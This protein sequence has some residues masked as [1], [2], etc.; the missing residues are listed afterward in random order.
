[1]PAP[2][3]EFDYALTTIDNDPLCTTSYINLADLG[4]A[5]SPAIAGNNI[6]YTAF[7][8]GAA[9]DFYGD[10][11][12]GLGIT[13]DGIIVFDP[14]T[15]Y[16]GTPGAP[17]TLPDPTA[18]NNLLALL[19]QDMEIVYNPAAGRGVSLAEIDANTV[20]VEFDE[21][22][23]RS[24]PTDTYTFELIARRTP[25]VA[26]GEFEFVFAY[27]RL[28]RPLTGPLTVGIENHDSSLAQA[29]VNNAGANNKLRNPFV[30]CL[31]RV[32]SAPPATLT[33]TATVTAA[34]RTTIVNSALIVTDPPG[35]EPE[36]A[37]ATLTVGLDAY[38]PEAGPDQAVNEGDPV[39]F[40]GSL[41]VP[42]LPGV[43]YPTT[44]NWD[45]S[46]SSS[47]SGILAP[48]HIYPDN[49]EYLVTFTIQDQEGAPLSDTLLVSVHN[50]APTLYLGGSTSQPQNTA[51]A[52]FGSFIDPGADTWTATVDYDGG[53]GEAVISIQVTGYRLLLPAVFAPEH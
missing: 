13:D 36:N 30:V 15:H 19:W 21:I 2:P 23:L 3:P 38:L 10:P 46:D 12:T 50:V 35:S 6:V 39:Q 22:Q 48:T 11:Y 34:P 26:A 41:V 31:D 40:E 42:D 51:F 5:P 28:T 4:I 8:G 16:A 45:F 29:Y 14:A 20:I 53:T 17:Q 44:I 24:D 32:Q 37:D 9:F 25:S 27:R 18:P 33:Y 47:S 7:T 1:M 49:G 43:P 52:R